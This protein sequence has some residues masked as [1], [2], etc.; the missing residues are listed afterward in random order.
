MKKLA[1][2]GFSWGACMG[3][4]MPAVEDRLKRQRAD[5]SRALSRTGAPGGRSDQFRSAGDDSD[6]NC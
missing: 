2:Y 4:I 3:A 1:F 5:G 6:V